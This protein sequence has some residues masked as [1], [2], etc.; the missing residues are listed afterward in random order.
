MR[1]FFAGGSKVSANPKFKCDIVG[2]TGY[3]EI[4]RESASLIRGNDRETIQA[5]EWPLSGIPAGVQE[6]VGLVD[7]GGQPVSPAR[8]AHRVV[9]ILVG[10]LESQRLGNVR[11]DLPIPLERRGLSAR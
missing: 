10:F 3:V 1:G 8:D 5:P 4:G 11:V 7:R 6:L 2:T 9:E